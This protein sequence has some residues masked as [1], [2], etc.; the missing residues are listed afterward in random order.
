LGDDASNSEARPKIDRG[1]PEGDPRFYKK[2][3]EINIRYTRQ[4]P[5]AIRVLFT[6]ST[7]CVTLIS[8]IQVDAPGQLIVRRPV[9]LKAAC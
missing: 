3:G 1:T 7:T 6:L 4:S 9:L 5:K 8:V 2:V